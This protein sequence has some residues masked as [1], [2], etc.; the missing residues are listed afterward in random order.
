MVIAASSGQG[1]KGHRGHRVLM[2]GVDR[3]AFDNAAGA[4]VEM[5]PPLALGA[6][7]FTHCGSTLTGRVGGLGTAGCLVV[8]GQRLDRIYGIGETG[9]MAS[10]QR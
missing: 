2:H 3:K 4:N 7:Q 9:Y 6:L 5:P 8:V 1:P 10:Q